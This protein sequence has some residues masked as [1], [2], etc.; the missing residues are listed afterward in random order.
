MIMEKLYQKL[1]I[2]NNVRM[3]SFPMQIKQNKN[4]FRGCCLFRVYFTHVAITQRWILQVHF[5]LM[6]LINDT[7]DD[8]NEYFYFHNYNDYNCALNITS[9]G[10][11]PNCFRCEFLL[12]FVTL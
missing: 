2:A 7:E 3:M 5:R 8:M 10:D 9:N 4:I 12:S 6:I 1:V 11:I